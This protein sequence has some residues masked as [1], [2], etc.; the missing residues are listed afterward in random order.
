VGG[1]FLVYHFWI[2]KRTDLPSVWPEG[3]VKEKIGK[4]DF[5]WDS[6][7]QCFADTYQVTDTLIKQFVMSGDVRFGI[8]K[9][10]RD[11]Y[12]VYVIDGWLQESRKVRMKI[13]SADST[14]VLMAIEDL[15]ETKAP[16]KCNCK[17][18]PY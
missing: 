1:S 5:V 4:S 17:P 11:P 8:S 15:P 13:E 6:S 14:S 18:I 3:S 16:Q 12:P 10:R 9:P 7:S 2:K